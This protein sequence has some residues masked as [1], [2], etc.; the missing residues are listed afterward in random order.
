[1]SPGPKPS[2]TVDVR[3]EQSTFPGVVPEVLGTGI[4]SDFQDTAT[5]TTRSAQHLEQQNGAPAEV[6]IDARSPE[7][8]AFFDSV[9]PEVNAAVAE[10]YAQGGVAGM[11][12][13]LV[14]R[15]GSTATVTYGATNRDGGPRP[16]R[17]TLFELASA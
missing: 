13:G 6:T 11:A 9:I 16:T 7:A 8:R 4:Q 1:M 17:R 15:D 5:Q 3:A 10:N 12:I 14:H 2:S